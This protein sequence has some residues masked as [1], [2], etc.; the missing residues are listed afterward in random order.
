MTPVP[1]RRAPGA[2]RS[3]PLH[4]GPQ[5]LGT[6]KPVPTL[7]SRHF[8]TIPNPY[9]YRD[10]YSIIIS[11]RRRRRIPTCAYQSRA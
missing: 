2:G 5:R 9:Y 7:R 10:H 11:S 6:T 4:G 3:T 8:S 1:T